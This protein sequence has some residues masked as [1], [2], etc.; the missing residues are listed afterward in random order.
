MNIK[1]K[2]AMLE[3]L[4]NLFDQL[5]STEKEVRQY[6]G[7]TEVQEQS[8]HWNRETHEYDLEFDENGE[9]VMEWVYDYIPKPD[10]MY[11]DSDKAKLSAV[12]TV[13][14]ALEKLV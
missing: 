14:K 4:E 12:D 13:R 6:W 1:T 5:D 3:V 2:K 8:K 10:D 11:D 7:K 9:P